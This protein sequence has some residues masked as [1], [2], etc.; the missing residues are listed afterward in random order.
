MA[1]HTL[2]TAAAAT[3]AAITYG[4]PSPAGGSVG[5]GQLSPADL[6]AISHGIVSD[7]FAATPTNMQA[8]GPKGI[9]ATGS[10]HSN[11]TLDTLVAVAGGPLAAIKVGM[12]VLGVG[13]PPGTYVA[14]VTS[15]TAVALSQAATASAT[16]VN[17]IFVPLGSA[18]GDPANFN[19]QLMIPGRGIIKVLPGDVIA[20][21]NTGWP[22]L[23]SAASIGY[24]GSLWTF[25]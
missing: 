20:V 23:V 14:S 22:I 4:Q 19:G 6:A 9:L 7:A 11:V 16:G 8:G 17:I 2:V 13:I 1:L 10:T 18:I 12:L 3:L 24:A 25:T 21:D 5:T 15:G